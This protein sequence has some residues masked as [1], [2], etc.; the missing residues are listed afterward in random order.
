MT[1]LPFLVPLVKGAWKV[2]EFI[3]IFK[4]G[5]SFCFF[6]TSI[7][8]SHLFP[9]KNDSSWPLSSAVVIFWAFL[10]PLKALFQEK[11]T[12]QLNSVSSNWGNQSLF[13][14]ERWTLGHR[15]P[16]SD[17]TRRPTIRSDVV[18]SSFLSFEGEIGRIVLLV[19]REMWLCVK[20][21]RK[22]TSLRH[23]AKN[24]ENSKIS[25]NLRRTRRSDKF[26]GPATDPAT[27][28]AT[29]QAT[30][31]AT[32]TATVLATHPARNRP[33]PRSRWW[34]WFQHQRQPPSSFSLSLSTGDR[35]STYTSIGSFC[36][37]MSSW[38]NHKYLF[39]KA[40]ISK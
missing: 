35:D 9:Q 22:S 19:L 23:A 12:S 26:N 17:V 36:H 40:R 30:D 2:V 10:W 24:A 3:H 8:S 14:Q 25:K 5:S 28:L 18:F 38:E 27:D 11:K 20:I 4:S 15:W 16:W 34:L 32:A 13:G 33:R 37:F 1:D 29:D 31:S 7:T 21:R 6:I 39:I